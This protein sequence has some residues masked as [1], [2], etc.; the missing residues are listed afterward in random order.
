MAQNT[1]TAPF[2]DPES[3]AIVALLNADTRRGGR[4]FLEELEEH[5]DNLPFTLY[6]EDIDPDSSH[7]E[8]LDPVDEALDQCLLY[9]RDVEDQWAGRRWKCATAM[10]G[11]VRAMQ[12]H[13]R[14]RL[15]METVK[16]PAGL[17]LMSAFRD[18]QPRLEVWDTDADG[19]RTNILAA[20]PPFA[21][22]DYIDG[23]IAG[24]RAGYE[25]GKI[26]GMRT[27]S[28]AVE[29]LVEAA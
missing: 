22:Q 29:R 17:Q 12:W 25:S 8:E 9:A 27:V 7:V 28:R 2:L 19:N 6:K 11:C 3:A 13:Y 20:L 4:A 24:M 15:H 14:I 16:A 1:T 10:L 5:W 21:S 18:E 26:A 23:A